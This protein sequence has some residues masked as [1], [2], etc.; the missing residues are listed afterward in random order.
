MSTSGIKHT[1]WTKIHSF[2]N[3]IKQVRKIK[4]SKVSKNIMFKG[5]IKLHGQNA[6]ITIGKPQDGESRPRIVTQTRRHIV[7]EN[8]AAGE[9]VFPLNV[10][11]FENLWFHFKKMF[12]DD[13]DI[14][15]IDQF[16]IFGEWCGKG[17][18]K[19]VAVAELD[20]KIFA[21]FAI[22]FGDFL[23]VNPDE[24][25]N[26]M[27]M[28]QTIEIPSRIYIL[29]WQTNEFFI[30][31]KNEEKLSSVLDEIDDLVN[32]YCKC[33][34]W[35]EDNFGIQGLGEGLV[36]YPIS[37]IKQTEN[38][39]FTLMSCFDFGKFGFKAKG[40]QFRAVENKKSVSLKVP[41]PGCPRVISFVHMVCTEARLQQGVT[42]VDAI[43]RPDI[44][45]LMKWIY[46]DISKE[47]QLELEES[48][49]TFKMIRKELGMRVKEWFFEQC[50]QK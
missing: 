31:F 42:E 16:T 19:H 15:G 39:D 34:P 28:N 35:V 49:F 36:L 12:Q 30:N 26:F 5:K 6:G 22:K 25:L 4:D 3:V 45:D 32:K 44:G 43:G 47:C 33:D 37:K 9:V 13:D 11:F 18:Q 14:P 2:H 23:M 17:I 20:E 1:F 8:L 46:K 21:I 50:D 7:G 38:K 24:I 41:K 10:D 40:E 48:G 27:T 29:P